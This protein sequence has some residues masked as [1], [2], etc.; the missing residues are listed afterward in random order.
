LN[1]C[2]KGSF[3]TNIQKNIISS[4]NNDEI[5]KLQKL[6]D[7]LLS[8]IFAEN[9]NLRFDNYSVVHKIK[10]RNVIIFALEYNLF[11]VNCRGI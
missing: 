1:V 4:K 6:I 7:I 8:K 3:S 9:L 10:I 2:C 5:N 11:R